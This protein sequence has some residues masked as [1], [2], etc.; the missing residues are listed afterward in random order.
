MTT[1]GHHVGS[2]GTR[3]MHENRDTFLTKTALLIN[4]EHDV[5]KIIPL[6]ASGVQAYVFSC[7]CCRA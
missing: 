2:A 5:I 7:N 6:P 3:W 1:S 4:A